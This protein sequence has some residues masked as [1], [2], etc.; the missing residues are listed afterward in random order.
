MLVESGR[1]TRRRTVVASVC[2]ASTT[3]Q[4]T[5]EE[6]VRNRLRPKA[7]TESRSKDVATTVAKSTEL[8]V[9][10]GGKTAMSMLNSAL[11]SELVVGD[12]LFR[13]YGGNRDL[14]NSAITNLGVPTAFQNELLS[15]FNDVTVLVTRYKI[16]MH[17]NDPINPDSDQARLQNL[18]QCSGKIARG[19]GE[20]AVTPAV[21]SGRKLAVELHNNIAA[22]GRLLALVFMRCEQAKPYHF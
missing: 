10:D 13:A 15:F 11:L 18:R 6:K 2:R 4:R 16:Y 22:Q 9:T 19:G 1:S 17:F 20:I 3:V 5:V 8:L 12:A 14:I 7:K 21:I